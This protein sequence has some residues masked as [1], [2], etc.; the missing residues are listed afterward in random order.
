MLFCGLPFSNDHISSK[1]KE[2]K[3]N[4]NK[5]T[6][7]L[8]PKIMAIEINYIRFLQLNVVWKNFLEFF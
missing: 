5:L 1:H 4:N 8:I 2:N 3:I 6:A 7:K